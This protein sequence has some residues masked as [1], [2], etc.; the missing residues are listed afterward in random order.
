MYGQRCYVERNDVPCILLFFCFLLDFGV[1][2]CPP[3]PPP[4]PPDPHSLG[5]DS[6]ARIASR[7][8]MLSRLHCSANSIAPSTM[9]IYWEPHSG[10]VLNMNVVRQWPRIKVL[11]NL[12]LS[13]AKRLKTTSSDHERS[14]KCS[15]KLHIVALRSLSL[16]TRYANVTKTI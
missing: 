7:S 13:E 12:K 10:A 14:C 9:H 1:N 8:C 6:T 15:F 2:F 4:A 16:W 11:P 3:S 5:A